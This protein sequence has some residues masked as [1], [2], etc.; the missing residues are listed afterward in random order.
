MNKKRLELIKYS[1]WSCLQL[2]RFI[3]CPLDEF[4]ICTDWWDSDI[5]AEMQL[6]QS[7]ISRFETFMNAFLPQGVHYS[8]EGNGAYQTDQEADVAELK[9]Y[10]AQIH[11]RI[12]LNSVHNSLYHKDAP[13]SRFCPKSYSWPGWGLLFQSLTICSISG[14]IASAKE[15]DAG[16]GRLATSYQQMQSRDGMG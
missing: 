13:T 15:P 8:E 16:F 1:Y 7:G 10:W 6:P 11:L 4:G 14:T 9:Y 12:T 5:L 3:L 2:E